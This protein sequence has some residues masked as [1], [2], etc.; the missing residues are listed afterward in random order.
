MQVKIINPVEH[1]DWDDEIQAIAGTTVYH[2]ADWARVIVDSYGYTPTYFTVF[3][4]NRISAFLPVMDIKSVLTGRRGVSLPFTDECAFVGSSTDQFNHI[5]ENVTEYGKERHWKYLELRGTYSEYAS[6]P[7]FETFLVHNVALQE[8]INQIKAGFRSST[9][10]N[11][12]K[13]VKSGVEI[14]NCHDL[15]SVKCFYDLN[16]QTRKKHRLPPQPLCFFIKLHEHIIAKRK[17]YVS[18]AVYNGIPVAGAVFI[19]HGSTMVYKYGASL[20]EYLHLRANNLIMWDAIQ[21]AATHGYKIFSFGRTEISNTGLLQFKRG[22]GATE[23]EQKYYKF[24]FADN[25]FSHRPSVLK[26]SYPVFQ[27]LPIS[28]LKLVGN[29]LYRHVG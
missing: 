21:R 16:C 8:D 1:Q 15:K 18:L 13:A 12:K 23:I 2:T 27:Y 3:N 26:T 20:S 22:W 5:W 6:Y 24:Y 29:I 17:G 28:M 4:Q 7:S 25:A 9:K 10:R 14:H 19:H 11:I